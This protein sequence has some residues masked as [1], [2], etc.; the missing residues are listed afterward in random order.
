MSI[1]LSIVIVCVVLWLILEY[2]A[3]KLPAPLGTVVIIIVVLMAIIWLL[4]LAGLKF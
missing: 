2:L 3:P 1:L 4:N